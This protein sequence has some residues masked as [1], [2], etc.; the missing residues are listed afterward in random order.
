LNSQ[1]LVGVIFNRNILYAAD[2]CDLSAEAIALLNK[3]YKG[4]TTA[5]APLPTTALQ[6][7]SKTYQLEIAGDEL[8]WEHGLMERDSMPANHGMIF[9]FPQA[10]NRAFWM[11]HTRFPLDV[12]FVDDHGKVVSC[13]TMKAYDEHSTLSDFPAKY[14]VELSA[15][16]IAGSGIKAGYALKIPPAVNAALKK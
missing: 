2:G 15:G 4:P 13:H 6:I 1:T 3:D 10:E 14:V 9:V 7:G 16:A 8:S 12:L 5:S 11:H